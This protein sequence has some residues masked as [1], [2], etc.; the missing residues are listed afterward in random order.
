M[1]VEFAVIPVTDTLEII[2]AGLLIQIGFVYTLYPLSVVAFILI[3]PFFIKGTLPAKS[4]YTP[5]PEKLSGVRLYLLI[6]TSV[7]LIIPRWI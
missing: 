6:F 7:S 4:E 2:D 5:A 1:V 3:Y